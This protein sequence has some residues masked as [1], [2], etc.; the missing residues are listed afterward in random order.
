MKTRILIVFIVFLLHNNC[1]FA[2]EE[3]WGYIDSYQSQQTF[4]PDSRFIAIYSYY[5]PRVEIFDTE[6]GDI[7]HTLP[8]CKSPK[9]T[10]DGRFL[11][12]V[13]T[14][15]TTADSMMIWNTETWQLHSI[16]QLP[17]AIGQ[18]NVYEISP[19]GKYLAMVDSW[20]NLRVYSLPD[21]EI[22]TNCSDYPY[23]VV[24]K[25]G[26]ARFI[27]H[28]SFSYDSKYIAF[29]NFSSYVFDIQADSVIKTVFSGMKPNFSNTKNTFYTYNRRLI[30]MD[31]PYQELGG[32]IHW[33]DIYNSNDKEIILEDAKGEFG[34]DLSVDDKYLAYGYGKVAI[35]NHD[36]NQES[37]V[38]T[39]NSAMP[40]TSVKISTN[41]R[42]LLMCCHTVVF[43]IERLTSF[44]EENP[45][46]VVQIDYINDNVSGNLQ[47]TVQTDKMYE[48]NLEL[49]DMTGRK[50]QISHP[51]LFPA[52]IHHFEYSTNFL[53]SGVYILNLYYS[54]KV[55][56]RTLHVVR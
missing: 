39:F 20:D 48:L 17:L 46:S 54:G 18:H 56:S 25:W 52:G 1:G 12:A 3:M 50:T 55:L 51:E 38:M 16:W 42:R 41:M 26:A 29:S 47:I 43:N 19:D 37:I 27:N 53:S 44:T 2:Q 7:L 24:P 13:P 35:L 22:I 28:L 10:P 33:K 4:S 32:L 5:P 8:E 31:S 45:E 23:H 9:F 15:A 11:Y 14:G 30:N 36:N 34:W 21:Y 49:V 40:A 6:T